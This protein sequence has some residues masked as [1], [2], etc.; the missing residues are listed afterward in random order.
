MPRTYTV[1]NV[2]DGDRATFERW[3]AAAA[4]RGDA[5]E[6]EMTR[7]SLREWEREQGQQ[8]ESLVRPVC[9]WLCLSPTA[10]GTSRPHRRWD[11]PKPSWGRVRQLRGDIQALDAEL[12]RELDGLESES[13]RN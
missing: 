6:A 1:R 8:R 3:A 9:G 11:V 12:G 4:A 7:E 2:E 5:D 13:D 10:R